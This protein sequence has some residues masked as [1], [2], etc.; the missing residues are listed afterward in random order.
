MDGFSQ[1]PM[2]ARRQAKPR[3][4]YRSSGCEREAAVSPAHIMMEDVVCDIQTLFNKVDETIKCITLSTC[5]ICR[6]CCL[7]ACNP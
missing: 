5:P 1:Q 7:A 6:L 2:D 4:R 3:S